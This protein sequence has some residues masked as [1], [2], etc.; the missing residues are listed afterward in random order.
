MQKVL[1]KRRDYL[2]CKKI[3]LNKHFMKEMSLIFVLLFISQAIKS[4]LRKCEKNTHIDF[5]EN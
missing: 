5:V 2:P 4:L 3:T 1:C